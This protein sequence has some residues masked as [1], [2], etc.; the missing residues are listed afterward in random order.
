M[1]LRA[2]AAVLGCPVQGDPGLEITGV[3]SIEQAGPGDLTFLASPKFAAKVA[4]SRA[5]AILVR[6]P[7]DGSSISSVIS[8]HPYLDFTRVMALFYTPP[9]PAP[10]ISPLASVDPSAV[11]EDGARIAPF[12]CI[13]PRVRLG[14]NAVLHPHVVLAG[15]V[16]IGDDFVAHA[17]VTVREHCR[18]GH[19]VLL[20][21]GV[22]IGADGFGFTKRPDGSHAKVPQ[23]GIVVIE[24]DVEIQTHSSVDRATMGETRVKRGARIDSH[25]QVGHGST[26]GE[27]TILCAQV[28]LSGSTVLGKNV[29]LAGQVG[30][31]DHVTIGDGVTAY[32][33]TGIL[34]DIEAGRLLAGA[35]ALDARVFMR[36]AAAFTK[37][38][39]MQRRLRDLEAQVAEL[40]RVAEAAT[41]ATKK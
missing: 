36:A 31:A 14:R 37:L 32:A 17:H 22:V 1:E 30:V 9:T 2:I 28:G 7:V 21:D 4:H 5:G 29:T 27:D 3:A 26:V 20:Q 39:E 13:G 33:Q 12:V 35:P 11:I 40:T 23:T 16:V 34:G 19:R 25:V 10:G 24:D 18:I 6:Q 41:A 8:E 15:D 38:P